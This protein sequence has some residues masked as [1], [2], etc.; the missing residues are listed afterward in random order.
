MVSLTQELKDEY[1]ENLRK[2]VVKFG[3][4]AQCTYDGLET[5]NVYSSH[6]GDCRF[7]ENNYLSSGSLH[8]GEDARKFKVT[9][10]PAAEL[11]DIS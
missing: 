11:V 7:E 4:L 1:L 6:F 8:L 2:E 5:K 10:F 9:V 3:E